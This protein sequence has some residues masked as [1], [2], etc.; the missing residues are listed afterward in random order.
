MQNKRILIA[1]AGPA[2]LTA[3]FFLKR[4]GF[5]PTIVERAPSLP[6]GGYKIDVRGKALEILHKMGIHEAVEKAGTDM[7]GALLV[8]KKGKVI[9]QMD[10]D[11]YGHRVSDDLEIVRGKLCQ[12]LLENLSE[13]ECFFDDSIKKII[14]TPQCLSVEF[15]QAG[16]REFDLIIGA[17]G[18]HSQVRQLVFGDES[19]FLHELGLYLCVFSIPNYLQLDR[20]EMEYAEL[21]RIAAVWSS[22]GEK[23]MKA[24]FGFS[25][26]SGSINLKNR[27]EQQDRL[28]AIYGDLGWEIPEFLRLMPETEDFYFDAAAQIRM[29]TWSQGRV[30]LAGD[31]GY[32]ASPM[33]GQGTSLA[34]IGAYV[35]AGELVSAKGDYQQAFKNYQKEMKSFVKA[36]Q[37]LGITAAKLMK[38]GEESNLKSRILK[39]LMRLIPGSLYQFFIQRTKGR[40]NYAANAITL[41]NYE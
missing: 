26:D 4:V 6:L 15:R 1:G 41:K 17:D 32:C 7:Q 19:C 16:V 23:T 34:L 18:V 30:V 3:A 8:D 24:C 21:G 20:V 22:S 37:A 39:T 5:T 2:G 11:T 29:D 40:I 35:L 12:I 13:V 9:Q 36:N 10:S 28:K 14:Q 31:A 33:S 25:A 27:E 38:S